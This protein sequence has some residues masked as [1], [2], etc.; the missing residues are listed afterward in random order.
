M[1]HG[2]GQTNQFNLYQESV[3]T[4]EYVTDGLEVFCS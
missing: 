1:R 4:K 2:I 3:H